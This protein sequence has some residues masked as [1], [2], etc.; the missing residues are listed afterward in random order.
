[1]KLIFAAASVAAIGAALP[2]FAQA[3]DAAPVTGLYG[4]LGYAGTDSSGVDLGAIQG[5]LGYRANNWLG[6][7]GEA[8]GGVKNDK[9]N[10]APGVDAKVKLEH[11]EA[12][13]GVG[14]LPLTQKWDLL[15]RVGY[16]H[17]KASASA[18]GV[19]V[20][21]SGDSWNYGAGAQ[22]HLDG[23]NGIRADYTRED[24]QSH[25]GGHADV[26]SVA[27]MRKF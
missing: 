26:W 27:Y 1:M 13:Y 3:Q 5:R 21:D 24:F 23:A 20:S 17:T 15:G 16:G 4:T 7:E 11:Q 6:L 12:I 9:V 22:Y 19:K 10:V 25:S 2:A 18:S 14:F 8:S